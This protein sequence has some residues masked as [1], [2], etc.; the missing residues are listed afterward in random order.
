MVPKATILSICFALLAACSS[1]PEAEPADG[2][3]TTID[4]TLFGDTAEV[5]G[6]QDLVATFE[7]AN[8]DA[9]VRLTPVASQ[10]DLLASLT[11]AF[12]GGEPPDLFLINYR[13]Y[14]QFAAEGAL[15]PA[16]PL[17]DASDVLSEQ[18]LAPAALD[19]FRFDGTELTCV[20]QNISSLEVYWN[21]DLFEAAGLDAPVAGWTWG[22]FLSTAQAL[23]DGDVYGLGTQPSII[24]V[25][26]FVWSNGGELVDDQV[27][28][29]ALTL[30]EGKAREA[31]DWFLPV[32]RRTHPDRVD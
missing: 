9:D 18:D 23:T 27:N 29:T 6:Y 25:A 3:A 15:A 8:P 19:A 30:T 13:R 31:L 12:A 11:T 1:T 26:P 2:Q 16:Q 14:G 21:K 20:P 24:R 32:D 5:A 10:D 4:L 28:P 17:L 22:D 7:E